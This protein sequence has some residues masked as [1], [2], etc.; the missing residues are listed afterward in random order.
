MYILNEE[1]T[2]KYITITKRIRQMQF[3][4][5]FVSCALQWNNFLLDAA[6]W[7]L[8]SAKNTRCYPKF[9]GASCSISEEP[10]YCLPWQ[11]AFSYIVCFCEI[12]LWYFVF[13]K[14]YL[15]NLKEHRG[16]L[17]QYLIF[18]TKKNWYKS[19]TLLTIQFDPLNFAL[20]S[21]IRDTRNVETSFW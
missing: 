2:I 17:V 19:Q 13:V 12:T 6:C 20:N 3:L 1:I 15:T 10:P 8:N 14:S 16:Y 18:F 11:A 5:N 7:I 9:L 21:G 4:M